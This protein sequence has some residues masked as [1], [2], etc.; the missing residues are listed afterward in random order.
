MTATPVAFRNPSCDGVHCTDPFG[1][2]RRYPGNFATY[3]NFCRACWNHENQ[4]LESWRRKRG[5]G[6]KPIP[7]DRPGV[8]P[9][10][11]MDNEAARL[12]PQSWHELRQLVL[13]HGIT[14]IRAALDK[15]EA[16]DHA[17]Q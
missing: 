1:E 13:L 5:N 16:E 15:I 8:I 4:R 2:V 12:H 11:N 9:A 10:N 7:W 14:S 3:R 6:R 17:R